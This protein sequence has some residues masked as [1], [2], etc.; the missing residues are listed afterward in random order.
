[1]YRNEVMLHLIIN[2]FRRAK[3]TAFQ[4]AP[5]T[6]LPIENIIN[7]FSVVAF[8]FITVATITMRTK[9]NGDKAI[10]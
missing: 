5:R 2:F 7:D 10:V 6:L 8:R 4:L 9:N 3:N 1:M